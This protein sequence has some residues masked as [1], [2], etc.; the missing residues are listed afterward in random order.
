MGLANFCLV[1]SAHFWR[2]VVMCL[3]VQYVLETLAFLLMLLSELI[4]LQ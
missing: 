3:G 1:T 4:P 2:E